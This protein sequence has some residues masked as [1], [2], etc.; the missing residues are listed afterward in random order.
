MISAL[1]EC[2]YSHYLVVKEFSNACLAANIDYNSWVLYER[3]MPKR[4]RS[5]HILKRLEWYIAYD[6]ID[7]CFIGI[8]TQGDMVVKIIAVQVHS[9]KIARIYI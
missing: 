9:L 1:G 5:L 8:D 2:L 6:Y 3:C 4:I 7:G